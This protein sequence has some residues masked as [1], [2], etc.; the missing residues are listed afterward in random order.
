MSAIPPQWNSSITRNAVKRANSDAANTIVIQIWF[1]GWNSSVWTTYAVNT[2][3]RVANGIAA[4]ERPLTF[5]SARATMN[6]YAAEGQHT[7]DYAT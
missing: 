4:F 6:E 7:Q 5:G 1:A 2:P 3:A